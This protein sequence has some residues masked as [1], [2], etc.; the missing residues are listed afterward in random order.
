VGGFSGTR[1]SGPIAYRVDPLP[2]A[3]PT[4]APPTTPV[5][6][7]KELHVWTEP[8]SKLYTDDMGCFSVCSCSGNQYIM[9]A[10]HCDSNAILVEPFQSRNDRHRIPA[11]NRLMSRL[12]ARGHIVDHQHQVLDN[13]ASA[14][15][16]RVITEDWK[17]TY[18]LVPPDIHRCNLAERAIQTFKAHLSWKCWQ[19]VAKT[20]LVSGHVSQKLRVAWFTATSLGRKTASHVSCPVV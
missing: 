9:L 2:K 6:P 7:S 4:A 20:C 14:E 19:H 5:S 1:D 3:P 15:Y 17:A 11:Y 13:E 16:I 12:K 8:I 10:Y 18:Q